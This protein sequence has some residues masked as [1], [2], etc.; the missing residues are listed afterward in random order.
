MS[1]EFSCHLQVGSC[2]VEGGSYEP[3]ARVAQIASKKQN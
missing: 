1:Y 2:K 3:S